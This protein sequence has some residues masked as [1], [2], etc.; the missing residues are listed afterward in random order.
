M[1]HAAVI[2]L[3]LL[4]GLPVVFAGQAIKPEEKSAAEAPPT[5]IPVKVQLLLTEFDGNE[6]V[7]SL[8]YTLNMLATMPHNTHG[9][10]LRFGVKVPI[11]TGPGSFTYNNVGTN[12]DG[13]AVIRPDGAYRLDLTVERS[14]VTMPNNGTDWKPGQSYPSTEPLIRSFTDDF[15]VVMRDGQTIQGT[16]AVDPVTGHVL[17]VDVTLTVLK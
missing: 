8:P 11:S 9:A 6:K 5:E 13:N 7:S 15:T 10:H 4:L 2:A 16:S 12:I 14:I 17:K 1:K 3:S